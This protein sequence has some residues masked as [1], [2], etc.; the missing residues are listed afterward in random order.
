[1]EIWNAEGQSAEN[2]SMPINWNTGVVKSWSGEM[3]KWWN[4]E[5]LK[6]S[7]YESELMEPWNHEI[8]DGNGLQK[9]GIGWNGLEQARVGWNMLKKVLKKTVKCLYLPN[10][11]WVFIFFCSIFQSLTQICTAL[12]LLSFHVNP[13]CRYVKFLSKNV[14]ER[15]SP[16]LW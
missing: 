12:V 7:K 1:M 4:Y 3:V 15:K 13:S 16:L 8:V 6:L 9:S 10:I 11:I 14:K 5:L 2:A